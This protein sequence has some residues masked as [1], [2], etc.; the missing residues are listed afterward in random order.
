MVGFL[1]PARWV[2]GAV[3]A[4]PTVTGIANRHTF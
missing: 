3:S 1:L 4:N 2:M